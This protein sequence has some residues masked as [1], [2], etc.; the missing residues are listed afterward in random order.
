MWG[1]ILRFGTESS[2]GVPA[3][4]EDQAVEGVGEVGQDPFRLGTGR[5]RGH[6]F[7]RRRATVKSG[8]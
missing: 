7:A 2:D 5:R 8:V 1:V 4:M 6:R 3:F